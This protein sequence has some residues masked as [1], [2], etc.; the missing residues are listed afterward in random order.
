MISP[1]NNIIKSSTTAKAILERRER[2]SNALLLFRPTLKQELFFRA[3]TQDQ[4]LE[5]AVTGLNRGGK[6]VA[7]A[8]WF[9]AVVLDEP[10]TMRNGE[11][12]HMRPRRWAGE[13]LLCWAVG[14]D[15]THNGETMYRLLFEPGLFAI[16]KDKKT[17]EYRSY[18][19]TIPGDLARKSERKKAPALIHP[20]K[21]DEDSWAWESKKDRQL[22]S[23]RL[24]GD[25]TRVVFYAS[26]GEVAAGN[27]VHVIWVDEKIQ[28]DSHY[29][30]WLMRL[31]DHEGRLLWSCWP[32]LGG[33]GAFAALMERAEEQQEAAESVPP[34]A[35]SF[36][37]GEKDNP[38]TDNATRQAALAT[39]DEEEA[40][41]RGKGISSISRWL[42]YPSF[43]LS[44]HR[45]MG[46]NPEGDDALAAE[47]R[48][49][50][51]I[52]ADWTRYLI[53]DPGHANCALLKVAIPPPLFGMIEDDRGRQ[54]AAFVIPYWEYY[55]HYI[56][57]HDV[58]SNVAADS[59]LEVFEDF[60]CD[61]H[62]YRTT[63]M[64]MA[65]T[66][67]G[68]NYERAFAKSGLRCQRR[69]A[70]F[71]MGGDD[72]LLRANM[73]RSL[74][75]IVPIRG[76]GIGPGKTN[77]IQAPRLRLLNLFRDGQNIQCCPL[78]ARQLSRV[79][80][81]KDADNNPTD[82]KADR[83]KPHDLVDC[84]EYTAIK[85]DLDY[86]PGRSTSPKPLTLMELVRGEMKRLGIVSQPKEESVY[87]GAGRPV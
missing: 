14:Y 13:N 36:T 51:G 85:E 41:A 10:V 81:G 42:M 67:I 29:P 44:I 58:A 26:T 9:A 8:V 17:G 76:D 86:V 11:K 43:S 1:L 21:V 7:V 60:T 52:P 74:M 2:M 34:T 54:I 15:W 24:K 62:A 38:Y 31:V 5:V 64:G 79:R 71:S 16:I 45:V 28:A 69:G 72:T 82:K 83:Q 30:E 6:S 63:P 19:P 61:A 46:E 37:F 70:T 12:L 23:I 77:V 40:A 56:D 49:T 87:C 66:T 32:M 18:D 3:M 27:P 55:F 78:L 75:R 84:A 22:K 50:N 33:S 57:A 47:I 65:G 25:G 73:L 53:L 35:I 4:L 48:R 68:Q 20:S 39:M 59:R 80:R